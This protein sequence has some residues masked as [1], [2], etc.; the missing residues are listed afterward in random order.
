VQAPELVRGA[1]ALAPERGVWG[2]ERALAP[3]EVSS[4]VPRG[5]PS[6][7]YLACPIL[8]LPVASAWWVLDSVR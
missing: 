3:V 6:L 1:W 7:V 2:P 4:T 5:Y 8:I